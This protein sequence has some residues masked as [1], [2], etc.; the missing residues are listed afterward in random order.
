MK[1]QTHHV[2]MDAHRIKIERSFVV[3]DFVV[4]VCHHH[5]PSRERQGGSGRGIRIGDIYRWSRCEGKEN[6]MMH[7]QS[8]RHDI[9]DRMTIIISYSMVS[10][11]SCGTGFHYSLNRTTK[12]F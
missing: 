8:V 1:R 4:C 7:G 3:G 6:P 11:S 10:V 2:G 5:P 9:H 12:H